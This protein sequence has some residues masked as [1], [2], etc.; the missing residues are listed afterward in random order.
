[1]STSTETRDILQDVWEQ[2]YNHPPNSSVGLHVIIS[3]NLSVLSSM[4]LLQFTNI[5]LYGCAIEIYALL[6]S[7]I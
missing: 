2:L 6:V 3:G 4:K 5:C 1:M 7:V